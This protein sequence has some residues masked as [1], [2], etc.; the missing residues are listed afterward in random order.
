MQTNSGSFA[1]ACSTISADSNRSESNSKPQTAGSSFAPQHF[2]SQRVGRA[3]GRATHDL[4]LPPSG[5]AWSEG[6][7]SCRLIRPV[8][9]VLFG[10]LFQNFG[11]CADDE[12][13]LPLAQ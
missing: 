8:S 9:Q 12:L 13:L 4:D 10:D 2:Q 1:A 3:A 7:G 6:A 11:G 5:I